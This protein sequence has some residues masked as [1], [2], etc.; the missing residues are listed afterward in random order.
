[1]SCNRPIRSPSP[2]ADTI[3]RGDTLRLLAQA[4]DENG[5]PVDGAEFTWASS[6]VSVAT[7]DGAGLVHGR[8]ES[9]VTITATSGSAEGTA[10][11]TVANPDRAALVALYRETDGPN[12]VDNTNWLTDAP[13][14]DWYGVDTDASGR[15]VGLRLSGRWDNDSRQLLPHGLSGPIP[16]ELGNLANLTS[17]DL[18]R[19]E[20]TGPIPPELGNLNLTRL[21]LND[22]ELTGPIPPGLGDLANLR[23]LRLDR[24]ALTGAVPRELGQL[25]SLEAM[26]LSNNPE[27]AGA[28]PAGLAALNNLVALVAGGTGLCAPSDPGFQAWLAGVPRR[29]IS[30]CAAGGEVAAYLT[31]AVQSR[32]FP[33]PLV[34][35]EEALLR[36]FVTAG[37]T[38]SEG[39]PPVRARFYQGGAETH[40]E[41]IPGK[42]TPMPTEINEGTLSRSANAVIPADV[43]QPGLEMVIEVDPD[44]KL[45]A[46]LGV[47]RRIPETGR[48]TVEVKA[49]PLFDLT[50]IPFLWT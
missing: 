11:I 25:A 44:G 34:A 21:W 23:W 46:G 5:H 39:I 6:D 10:T 1:M 40:V 8:G 16:P 17:L 48:L 41:N 19:N 4:F 13:L 20:L 31:Q 45:D 7:V 38:T 28:L 12:W 32:E 33:V 35:G 42:A 14:G 3:A 18:R 30:S 15:V 26:G 37:R 24:N 36:V 29:R 47:T 43:V 49:M 22:N 2:S 27:L 50:V 9:T